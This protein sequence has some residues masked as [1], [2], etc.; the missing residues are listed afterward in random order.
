MAQISSAQAYHAFPD[1]GAIWREH[2]V[3]QNYNHS[4]YQYG[5]MGDTVIGGKPYQKVYYQQ[6]C[7]FDTTLTYSNSVLIGAIREDSLKRVF[8]Y[9]IGFWMAMPDSVYLLYDFSAGPGD[10]LYYPQGYSFIVPYIVVTSVDSVWCLNQ[11]RKR[12]HFGPLTEDWIEGIGSMRSLFSPIMDYP[13]CFCLWENVCYQYLDTTFYLNPPWLDCY[14]LLYD[15]E[16]NSN[17]AKELSIFPNPASNRVNI[18][19]D[20]FVDDATLTMFD[21]YG[22]EVLRQ[23]VKGQSVMLDLDRLAPGMYCVMLYHESKTR[24]KRLLIE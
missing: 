15:V 8:F 18:A 24:N 10:T 13:T 3:D 21:P 16:E 7:L 11:Y 9:N 22:K 12:F 17:V 5:M 4:H 19:F 2:F 23:S 6:T 20:E 1:S 14:D